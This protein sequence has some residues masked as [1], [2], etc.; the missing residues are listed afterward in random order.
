MTTKPIIKKPFNG[1]YRISF[2]FGENPSWYVKVFGKPH[3]GVD[4]ATP[5]GVPIRACA[6]GV[7]AYADSVPDSNGLGINLTHSWGMSQYWHLSKLSVKRGTTVN[8]GQVIG[9][10]GATGFVT[11]P[12]LHFGVKVTGIYVP[13]MNGWSNP[14]NYFKDEMPANDDLVVKPKYILVRPGDSLWKIAVREYGDGTRWQRIFN[15][16]RNNITNP[17][18]IYPLQKLLIP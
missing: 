3:N 15:A 18:L 9:I 12:H 6:S 10:S 16:N 7:V 13:G 14:L 1:D 8:C 4:F 11:G 5:V 2:R 17:A